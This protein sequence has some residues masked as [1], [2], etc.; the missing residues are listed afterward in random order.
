MQITWN[1]TKSLLFFLLIGILLTLAVLF[2]RSPEIGVSGKAMTLEYGYEFSWKAYNHNISTFLEDITDRGT[3]GFTRYNNP[4]EEEIILHMA[5]SLKVIFTA[6]M[7]TMIFGVLKGIYDFYD[8]W[9]GWNIFGKGLTWIVQSIPDFFLL[10]CLQ[11]LIIFYL[12]SIRIFGHDHW[13]SFLL[14]AFLVSLYPMMYVARI[15]SASLS[16]E[17]GKPYIQVARSKG[18]TS[19]KVL[20][21][22]MLRNSFYPILSNLPAMMLY[23]LSNLLIVEYLLDYRGAAY[24]MFQAFDVNKA[25]SG[26]MNFIN[27]SGLIIGFGL[28]FMTI[29]FI[30]QLISLFMLKLVEP[31]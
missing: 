11:W 17:K 23:L 29:V 26:S 16:N 14:P 24:R 30:S 18:L 13:Y 15:T 4:A 5:R 27:E 7:I 1:I 20:W 25:L 31:K 3:L 2:P 8:R 28:S 12:P 10:I 6:I 9:G 19:K 21:K 22:H